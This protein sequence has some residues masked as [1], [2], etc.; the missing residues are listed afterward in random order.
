MPAEGTFHAHTV[1]SVAEVRSCRASPTSLAEARSET[2]PNSTNLCPKCAPLRTS[3]RNA[4]HCEPHP[5]MR[6]VAILCL[7][8]RLNVTQGPLPHGNGPCVVG[9][10]HVVTTAAIRPK[11]ALPRGPHAS[12]GGPVGGDAVGVMLAYFVAGAVLAG[13]GPAPAAFVAGAHPGPADAP[14][15]LHGVGAGA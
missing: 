9:G 13:G 15:L 4:H 5:E 11:D 7:R 12:G 10:D 3:S 14:V 2:S 8:C 6:T 1:T